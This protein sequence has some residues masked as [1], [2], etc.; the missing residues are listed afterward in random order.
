MAATCLTSS[1]K[2]SRTFDQ[3]DNLKLKIVFS[4]TP[5]NGTAITEAYFQ[6]LEIK[7]TITENIKWQQKIFS[8]IEILRFCTQP[9]PTSSFLEKEYHN[10][11][12]VLLSSNNKRVASILSIG[13][14]EFESTCIFTYTDF[15]N[16]DD[17]DEK[18]T[19]ITTSIKEP[20]S[21]N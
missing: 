13:N 4:Q 11:I 6:I 20:K 21:A 12:K 16:Y 5:S 17:E 8:P 2:S 10:Q 7:N 3:P 9:P 15:D 18:A 1:V 14:V 19:T